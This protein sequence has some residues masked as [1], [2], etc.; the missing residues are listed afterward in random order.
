MYIIEL[1]THYRK[2]ERERERNL[3]FQLEHYMDTHSH[4]LLY[5]MRI[6]F[7]KAPT[8]VI[9]SFFR[10]MDGSAI[11]SALRSPNSN[12]HSE[13]SHSKSIS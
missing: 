8:R 3:D 13:L 7:V 1:K 10:F 12:L 4:N 2:G 6:K 5:M 11:L 9:A